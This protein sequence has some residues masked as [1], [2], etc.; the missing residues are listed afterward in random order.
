WAGATTE[1]VAGLMTAPIDQAIEAVTGETAARKAEFDTAS[2]A[3]SAFLGVD[4][5][6]ALNENLDALAELAS[7]QRA[8][9]ADLGSMVVAAAARSSALE[10]AL[11]SRLSGSTDAT[12]STQLIE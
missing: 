6:R 2:E 1:A 5:R 4:E 11:A 3:W 9:L 8:R 10:G 12:T 7:S